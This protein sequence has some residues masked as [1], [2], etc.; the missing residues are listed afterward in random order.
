MDSVL[1]HLLDAPV[2]QSTAK[3]AD[4]TW[5]EETSANSSQEVKGIIA[6]RCRWHSR[7]HHHL[8]THLSLLSV[9]QVSKSEDMVGLSAKAWSATSRNAIRGLAVGSSTH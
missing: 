7:L 9:R 5:E 8:E 6:M 2:V 4:I 3:S 1:A